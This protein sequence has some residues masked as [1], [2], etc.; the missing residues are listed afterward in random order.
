MATH[1]P[2]ILVFDVN[3]TLIDIQH[4]TPLFVRLFGRADAMRAW[5]AE[6]VL[7]SQS[8]SLARSYVPF[9]QIAGGVL[10]MMGTIHAV[11]VAEPDVD[12]LAARFAEMPPHPDAAP[13]LERL[14]AAGFRL[15]T[16]TNSPPRADG[17]PLRRGGL[18]GFFERRFSVDEVRRAKPAPETY[19]LV[20][21]ALDVAP[22]ELCLVAAHVWDTLGAQCFGARGA[23]I[24]RPGNAPLP[25]EGVPQPDLVAPDLHAF[26]DLAI[27]RWRV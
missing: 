5:F 25:A 26:A 22:D 17:G 6:L 24:L 2:S 16:L 13:S 18:E 7:Y 3:E 11:T 4:L 9:P 12:E 15:V 1:R 21:R 8:L 10:R 27:A 23:L 14:A 19:A 20:A